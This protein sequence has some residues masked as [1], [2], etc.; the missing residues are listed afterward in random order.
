MLLAPLFSHAYAA[1]YYKEQTDFSETTVPV[2]TYRWTHD[3]Q[4]CIYKEP[5]VTNKYYVW[6]KLAVQDWRNALREYTGNTEWNM[7]AHYVSDKKGMAGC[8]VK[9]YIHGTYKEFPDYPNQK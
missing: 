9:I 7:S 1:A 4:W 3:L 6:V 8:D 2:A 5:G